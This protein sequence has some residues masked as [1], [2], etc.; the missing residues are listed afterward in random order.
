LLAQ[1]ICREDTLA[2]L[3]AIAANAH[4][5]AGQIEAGCQAFEQALHN[6]AGYGENNRQAQ[7]Y[8]RVIGWAQEQ[9][10]ALKQAGCADNAPCSRLEELVH[11]SFTE[12]E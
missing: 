8:W 9:I 1:R 6:L 5:A 4:L 11:Q 3:E 7:Y 12:G 10:N 2:L